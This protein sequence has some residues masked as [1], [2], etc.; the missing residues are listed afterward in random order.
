[1]Y[2]GVLGYVLYGV[3]MLLEGGITTVF[4][5]LVKPED[6]DDKVLRNFG[7]CLENTTRKTTVHIYTVVNALYFI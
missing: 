4:S 2:C 5:I 3:T 6:G 7:N 1:M